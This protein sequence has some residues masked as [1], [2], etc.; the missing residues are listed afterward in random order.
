[1]RKIGILALMLVLAITSPG[2]AADELKW[3]TLKEGRAKAKVENKT[4]IVDFFYGKGCPRCEFLQTKAYDEPGIAE[5]IR[6]NFVPIRIDLT[7]ELS[8]E[9]EAL[10]KEH[11][12]KKDCLL[13]FLDPQGNI[14]KD[15]EGKKLCFIDTIDPDAFIRYLERYKTRSLSQ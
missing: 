13:L 9:E 7:K 14:I 5:E 4:M 8:A 6:A 11:D 15:P 1:M 10:G 3:F 2:G 12:Y